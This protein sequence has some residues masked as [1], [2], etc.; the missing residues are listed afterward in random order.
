MLVSSEERVILTES[1]KDLDRKRQ[2]FASSSIV[3]FNFSTIICF[4][5]KE[6]WFYSKFQSFMSLWNIFVYEN[7]HRQER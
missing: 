2:D 5:L 6:D 1:G 4:F 3:I 7:T